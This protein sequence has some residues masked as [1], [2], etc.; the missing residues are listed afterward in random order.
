MPIDRTKKAASGGELIQAI[1]LQRCAEH[2]DKSPTGIH[3]IPSSE[4]DVLK[5]DRIWQEFVCQESAIVFE[6][7]DADLL[8]KGQRFECLGCRRWHTAGIDGPAHTFVARPDGELEYRRLPVD[9]AERR[10]WL[11][12]AA[13]WNED[14]A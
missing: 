7:V 1:H 10:A 11:A 4:L 6:R 9:A 13:S 8:I 14:A 12:E 5:A 3:R 2:M